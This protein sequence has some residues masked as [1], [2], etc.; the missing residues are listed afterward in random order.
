[1]IITPCTA[2]VRRACSRDKAFFGYLYLAVVLR[3]SSSNAAKRVAQSG[4]QRPKN[5][6]AGVRTNR[7]AIRQRRYHL[8]YTVRLETHRSAWTTKLN[9]LE[10]SL[11]K[12]E[13]GQSTFAPVKTAVPAELQ[14]C[15]QS[16]F[17]REHL[18]SC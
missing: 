13:L 9:F 8:S 17:V 1:M 7:F 12:V 18:T 5:V 15:L 2:I 3:L 16:A 4:I 11:Q 10:L 14:S 6:S